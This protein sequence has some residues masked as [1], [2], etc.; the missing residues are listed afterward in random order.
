MSEVTHF[1][2]LNLFVVNT[3]A[4]ERDEDCGQDERPSLLSRPLRKQEPRAPT[5]PTVQ[6]GMV[7]TCALLDVHPSWDRIVGLNDDREPAERSAQKKR[8]VL[9]G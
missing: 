6:T 2:R 1:N 9:D 3:P 4:Y 7:I 5:I 8:S